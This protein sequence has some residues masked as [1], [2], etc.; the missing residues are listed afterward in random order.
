MKY[1][2]ACRTISGS[3]SVYF[4]LADPRIDRERINGT[5]TASENFE[6]LSPNFRELKCFHSL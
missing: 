4:D 6:K 1:G 2:I 3:L 5:S